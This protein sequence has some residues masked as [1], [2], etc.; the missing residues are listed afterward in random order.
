MHHNLQNKLN[1]NTTPDPQLTHQQMMLI[2][3]LLVMFLA[4][5]LPAVKAD[6]HNHVYKQGDDVIVWA[7]T[8]G[9]RANRQETYE[10]YQLPFCVG[11]KLHDHRHETLGEALQGMQLVNSGLEIHFKR[12]EKIWID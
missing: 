4:S 9:P 1:S 8:V 10:Y 6:E 11:Q 7:N 3:W 2:Q 12:N 5:G